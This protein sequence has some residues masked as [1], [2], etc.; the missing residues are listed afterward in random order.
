[1]YHSNVN[2]NLMEENIIQIKSKI[3]IHEDASEKKFF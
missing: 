2:I 3:M 1:M